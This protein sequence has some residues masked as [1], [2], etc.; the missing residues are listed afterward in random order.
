MKCIKNIKSLK[1]IKNENHKIDT[2][3]INILLHYN[4]V[5]LECLRK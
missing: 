1:K 2:N 3:D 5:I 4:I